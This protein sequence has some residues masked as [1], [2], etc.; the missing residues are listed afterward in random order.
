MR[1][2]QHLGAFCDQRLLAGSELLV[3]RQQVIKESFREIFLRIQ[4]GWRV[5]H[6]LRC[7][8]FAMQGHGRD[9]S[10][11]A[12]GGAV[13]SSLRAMVRDTPR[14]SSRLLVPAARRLRESLFLG[15]YSFF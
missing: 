4:I 10:K 7:G 11:C 13:W 1:R 3:Q 5:I 15:A 6:G 12:A 2:L 8:S 9:P 14:S